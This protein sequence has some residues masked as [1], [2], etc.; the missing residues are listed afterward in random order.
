MVYWGYPYN[1]GNSTQVAQKRTV[2]RTIKNIQRVKTWQLVILLILMGF[3]TATFLRLNNVG[4]VQRRDAVIAADKQGNAEV[5][6]NR[7]LDLQHYV[8]AHMNTGQ[9]DVYLAAQYERDKAALVQQAAA[10]G[11]SGEV[12]NAKVDA[13]CKPQFSSYNQGYVDCFAREYAKY[14]PGH[15]PV[16]QVKMPDTEK[17]RFV[18]A[19][20]L[21][22]ADFAGLSLVVCVAIVVVIIGRLMTLGLLRL[23]L[24]SKYQDI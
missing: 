14:A 12:I 16:S 5:T 22:S 2:R 17:Y 4:M 20:P 23:L 10:T 3:V 21:W 11:E 13:V 7:V 6:R 24:K 8:S 9:N 15:D 1:G 19:S 18:F